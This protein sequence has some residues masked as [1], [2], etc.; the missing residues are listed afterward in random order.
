M[1][2]G[3]LISCFSLLVIFA[4][5]PSSA[6]KRLNDDKF[7]VLASECLNKAVA[8][9]IKSLEFKSSKGIGLEFKGGYGGAE[10]GIGFNIPRSGLDK[11]DKPGDGI[12]CTFDSNG[13]ILEVLRTVKGNDQCGAKV[14]LTKGALG[15]GLWWC[16]GPQG[17]CYL[18]WWY[19]EP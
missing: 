2:L 18:D 13:T 17:N 16:T 3:A 15:A 19:I 6:A 4:A 5:G 12:C 7:Q 8:Q 14:R 1:K 10:A 9:G 11:S